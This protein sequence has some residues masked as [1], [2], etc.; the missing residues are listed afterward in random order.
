MG[1]GSLVVR[2][3]LVVQRRDIL[4]FFA[5]CA[6]AFWWSGSFTSASAFVQTLLLQGVRNSRA[7][8]RVVL[9]LQRTVAN[10]LALVCVHGRL[11]SRVGWVEE[12]RL[13]LVLAKGSGVSR[14]LGVGERLLV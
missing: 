1:E 2:V 4:V 6:S 12:R 3:V 13:E 8:E 5:W 14:A 11:V 7:V 10:L 9:V